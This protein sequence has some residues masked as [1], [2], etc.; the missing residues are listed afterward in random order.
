MPITANDIARMKASVKPGVKVEF[1][2]PMSSERVD[3]K[4]FVPGI[5]VSV[6]PYNF[7]VQATDKTGCRT[8]FKYTDFLL[9]EDRP[10]WLA[11]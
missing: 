1:Y 11:D 10:V 5:V 3:C 2:P 4:Y 9:S 7:T 6:K 8:S